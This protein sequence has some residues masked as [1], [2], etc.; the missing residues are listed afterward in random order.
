[1]SNSS[2]SG[3]EFEAAASRTEAVA[4]FDDHRRG[5]SGQVQHI[6]HNNPSMVP[7]IV[8]VAAIVIFG[9]LLG[10]STAE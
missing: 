5:F 4:E 6:L 8:L 10:L 2:K 7:L 1:M 3:Q 9:L